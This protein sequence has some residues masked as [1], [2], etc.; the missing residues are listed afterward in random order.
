M[1]KTLVA[2]VTVANLTQRGGSALTIEDTKAHFDGIIFGELSPGKWM[3][4]SDF[5]NR[6][7]K[8]Q[9]DYPQE[10]AG[11][12]TLIQ[13]AIVYRGTQVTLYRS[14]V[15]CAQ[16]QIQK[17]R[18]FGKDCF[19]VFGIRH[20]EA[21]DGACFNGTIDDARIYNVALT[22]DQIKALGA[23]EPSDPKPLAWWNFRDGIQD[24]MG[25]FPYGKLIGGAHIVNGGLAL[26]GE[27]GGF[28]AHS[29]ETPPPYESPI[30]F[31][32]A[33]GALADTIP[34]FSKGMY[35]VF[36]LHAGIAGTPWE[37]IVSKDLIHWKELPTALMP[38]KDDPDGPD[39][40]NMFTG[41]VIEHEGT[42]HIFYTGHNPR[43]PNG[44]ELICHATSPDGITWT[45]HPKEVFGADGVHYLPKSDFRDPYVFWNAKDKCFRMLLCTR[46]AGDGKPVVGVAQSK[47]L[48]N[49]RQIEP[50]TMDPPLNAGTPECP[51]VF[52]SGKTWYLLF[53][54]C[55]GTTDI[56]YAKDLNGP[57]RQSSTVSIDTS[58]LYAAKRMY[59]GKRHILV[60]WIRDLSGDR[61]NGDEMWG[62]D[63]C[64]PREAYE[65]AN[66]Q[67]YFKPVK[68]VVALFNGIQQKMKLTVRPSENVTMD[69][70]DNYMLD[71]R[72]KLPPHAEFTIAFRMQH[73]DANAYFLTLSPGRNWAEISGEGFSS[74]RSCFMDTSKPVKIQAFLQGTILEC[75]INDQYAFSRRAYDLPHGKIGLSAVG[76][77]AEVES[78]DVRLA[79]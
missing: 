45:K 18:E 26:T 76:G 29:Y 31:R 44:M 40:G 67:L 21:G 3:A 12:N 63:M 15:Q 75:F 5:Y 8:D 32:P 46:E 39:G 19:V 48:I 6:T 50:L 70:P 38:D 60:G 23:G 11:P 66:G 65:G 74:G 27:Y 54:P 49:W 24:Q 37:H 61:D 33:I 34:I 47:D 4:G 16:Y 36:Y 9:S 22:A 10:N 28:I 69:A 42:Y 56:R 7:Q 41:G 72:V 52:Q 43:N 57:W 59:D 62:G 20:L 2:W 78:L 55:A 35:H 14:G 17:P 25:A 73:N 68:E 64:L 51:D 79:K 53:S 13:I 77:A 58:I 71:C 1:D 30:H